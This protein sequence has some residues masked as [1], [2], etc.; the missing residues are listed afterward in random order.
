[1]K[2]LTSAA[3]SK[4]YRFPPESISHCVWLSF[5]FFLSSRYI[6]ELIAERGITLTCETVH[7]GA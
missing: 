6:E 4:G 7:S 5:R 2:L 1:M 3:N